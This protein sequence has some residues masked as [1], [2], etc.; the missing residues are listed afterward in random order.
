MTEEPFNKQF[1][2]QQLD[3]QRAAFEELLAQFHP[4]QM[5]TIPIQDSWTIKDILAHISAWERELLRWLDMAASGKPPDIPAPGAWTDYIERFNT[6]AYQQDRDR[7]LATVQGEFQQVYA[8]M[9]RALAEL[10]ENPEDKLW[11]VW[12]GGEPP[13]R[14]L[15]TFSEHYQEHARPIQ[16]WLQINSR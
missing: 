3:H 5:D 12:Y 15:A 7:P 10:P 13:W 1:V 14:L 2:L 6:D 9:R 16:E 4:S 8:R 11:S